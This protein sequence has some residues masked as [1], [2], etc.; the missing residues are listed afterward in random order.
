MESKL[1]NGS[2]MALLALSALLSAPS[3][4]QGEVLSPVEV[5]P[6]KLRT[7]V[8]R[9][10]PRVAQQLQEGLELAVTRHLVEGSFPVYFELRGNQ[11][12]SSTV[13]RAPTNFR[14]TLRRVVKNLDCQDQA[15]ADQPQRFGFILD[16][17]LEDSSPQRGGAQ[18]MAIALRPLD[19]L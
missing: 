7:D 6:T 14:P 11:V 3:W 2:R 19:Q 9:S 17:S 12:V 15:S 10:C 13:K 16:I 5:Q 4:A 18:R 1:W 8:Q